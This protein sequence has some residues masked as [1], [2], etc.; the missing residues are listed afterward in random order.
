MGLLS[1][2]HYPNYIRSHPLSFS[3]SRQNDPL[4][5]A[6]AFHYHHQRPFS[7]QPLHPL[8]I[9]ISHPFTQGLSWSASFVLAPLFNCDVDHEKERPIDPV[10]SPSSVPLSPARWFDSIFYCLPFGVMMRQWRWWKN[11][12]CFFQKMERNLTSLGS[13]NK[14]PNHV[15]YVAKRADEKVAISG[16]SLNVE[17]RIFP[18]RPLAISVNIFVEALPFAT[19][20]SFP[21]TKHNSH[22]IN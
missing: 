13:Y 6:V 21:C 9:I 1:R 8:V 18:T 10:P 14:R 22:D 16:M 5:R 2:I 17:I 11:E 7:Y 12:A 19:C 15:D 4:A 3:P 20:P